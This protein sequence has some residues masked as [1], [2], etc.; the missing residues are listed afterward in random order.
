M[1]Q[2]QETKS[3]NTAQSHKERVI[4]LRHVTKNIFENEQKLSKCLSNNNLQRI[5]S[6]EEHGS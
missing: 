1:D 6:T 2:N 4:T 5:E 3:K